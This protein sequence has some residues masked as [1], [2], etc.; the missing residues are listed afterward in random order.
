MKE[1][2]DYKLV[3]VNEK[4][5]FKIIEHFDNHLE[6]YGHTEETKY[7]YDLDKDITSLVRMHDSTDEAVED[8]SRKII[9]MYNLLTEFFITE[10]GELYTYPEWEG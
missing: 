3:P 6:F 1:D 8:I 4:L 7:N 9:K 10:K 2:E 5:L